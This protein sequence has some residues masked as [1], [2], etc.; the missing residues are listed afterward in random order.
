MKQTLSPILELETRLSEATVRAFGEQ[1]AGV[2]PLIRPSRFA[3]YQANV[4]LSLA[5]KLQMNPR[6][7][8]DALVQA[9][10]GDGFVHEP[11]VS[12][13]GYI[14]FT[15]AESW[16]AGTLSA[17]IASGANLA[18]GAGH[19]VVI[20]YSSPNVAKEMHVGHLRT[21]V[22]GDALSRIVEANGSTVIR[23]NHIGDWGTPF[24]MLIELLLEVGENSPTAAELQTDPNQFYQAA[25]SRFDDDPQFAERAR[26]RVVMLQAGDPETVNLWKKLVDQSKLYF[27]AIYS[28]LGVKLTD[29]DIAGESFY[30]DELS[31]LCEELLATGVAVES[32]GALVVL[33]DQHKNRDGSPAALVLRKSDGGYGYAATDLAALR[34]RANVLEVDRAFYVIGAP[35]ELHLTMVKEIA[36]R[37]GWISADFDF[38][39]VA[40]GS[41]LGEDGKMLKTRSGAPVRLRSLLDEAEAVATRTLH[42]KRP[43]LSPARAGE[44]GSIIGIGAVKYADLS[45]AHGTEYTFDLERMTA[46]NG[47]TGPYLQY[48]AVRMNSVLVKAGVTVEEAIDG[49]LQLNDSAERALALKLLD[50]VP[51]VSETAESAAIHRLC[52]YL[53]E[54]A[55]MF[56]SFYEACPI[57]SASKPEKESRLKLVAATLTT[58]STGLD[59][60]GIEVPEE[61]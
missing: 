40:I 12:G 23:Q 27:N 19:R 22:V 39:H 42:S 44:L 57:M 30:N 18:S 3:D 33:F 43:D 38:V 55:Q 47:N 50:F 10:D 9:F 6:A 37:A 26:K 54:L 1:Y 56:S 29:A 8:A 25:R 59:L 16:L 7:I 15:L 20:D 21:T 2:D 31:S 34:Y 51:T 61:M 17:Q 52:S 53:Y 5:K 32:N 24:G 49:A 4:A 58:L 14:N 28:K 46:L 11:E 36:E 13:P 35:Q 45:V 48:A 41:V 60:L